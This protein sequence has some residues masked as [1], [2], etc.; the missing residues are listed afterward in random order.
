MI[1]DQL[2][3]ADRYTGLNSLF[4]RAFEF[5]R[6]TKL[7][8]LSSGRVEIDGDRI[9]AIIA[10]G[11]GHSR[12]QAKLEVHRAYVDI[13]VAAAGVDEIGWKSLPLCTTPE[14]EYDPDGDGQV[15]ADAPD[16]WIAVGPGAFAI[17]FPQ[18]AH[19]P[20]VSD[21]ELHKVVVK[22]LAEL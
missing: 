7:S 16:A 2:D 5:L 14:G 17:F 15:L 12:E 10:K 8:N 9:F 22:V 6:S 13:Q 19:A 1:L 20:M 11:P 18:D 3:Q 4:P 21:G